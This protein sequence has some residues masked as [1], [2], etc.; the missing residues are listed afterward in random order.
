MTIQFW[1]MRSRRGGGRVQ[2]EGINMA[3]ANNVRGRAPGLVFAFMAAPTD[4][5]SQSMPAWRAPVGCAAPHRS[6]AGNVERTQP[7]P[8]GH[9]HNETTLQGTKFFC[10]TEKDPVLAQAAQVR[11]D[12][13][14]APDLGSH[15]QHEVQQ[16]CQTR[17]MR[18][19]PG[20]QSCLGHDVAFK[21]TA[22]P[23][24]W[25]G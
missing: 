24:S 4:R 13:S 19:L 5:F 18:A 9:L 25:P 12:A 7:V 22:P 6:L 10:L 14:D 8:R 11:A 20:L 23:R 17:R 21:L 3:A 15:L 2:G 1:A 16:R